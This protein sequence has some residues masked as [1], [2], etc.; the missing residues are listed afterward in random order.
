MPP[1]T[2]I[3]NTRARAAATNPDNTLNP[4]RDQQSSSTSEGT[5]DLF[6][7]NSNGSHQSGNG[8]EPPVDIYD[9][10]TIPYTLGDYYQPGNGLLPTQ[11]PP[12]SV[13]SADAVL[14]SSNEEQ[15]PCAQ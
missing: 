15:L 11:D 4:I 14:S 7:D 5:S 13:K 10:E 3:R 9:Q 6:S 1:N 8:I 2:G 12:S